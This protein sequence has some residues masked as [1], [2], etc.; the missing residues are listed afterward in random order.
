MNEL[1]K[2]EIKDEKQ[3][4]NARDLYDFLEINTPYTQWF[5]RMCGYGFNENIDYTL[6]SQ[7][8]E[9]SNITGFKVIQYHLITIDMAKELAM[10]QRT[11]KGKQARQYFIK[12]E[13]AWNNEDMI[14]ARAFQIQK[15]KLIN[16]SEKIKI[17]ET[18]IEQDKSKVIFAEAL[19]ISKTSILVGEL[20]KLI[21][22]NG[23]EIGA[24]RL[25][26]WLR[27]KGYLGTK[28]ENYNIPT[29]KSMELKLMEIKKSTSIN[30]D[31]SIRTNRTPKITGKGQQYF[32][33]KFLKNKEVN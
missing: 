11:E 28:G 8:C 3:L 7:K 5:E 2:I 9:S 31:G 15:K 33:N 14:L 19:E 25:F 26:E 24:N 30:S 27:D 23:V 29:Q 18:K 21:K 6:Y 22:Q 4:V 13:E 17:L 1:I 16:Y 32:I 10:L 12:C 20:A